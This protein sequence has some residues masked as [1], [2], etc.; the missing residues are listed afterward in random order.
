[1][2]LATKNNAIIVKDGKLAENCGCCGGWY[3]YDEKCVSCQSGAYPVAIN[4]SVEMHVNDG[5]VTFNAKLVRGPTQDQGACASYGFYVGPCAN[6]RQVGYTSLIAPTVQFTY[7]DLGQTFQA[8]F[9][10]SMGIA[11]DFGGSCFTAN[12]DGQLTPYQTRLS[13]SDLRTNCIVAPL[14]FNVASGPVVGNALM[15]TSAP[16]CYADYPGVSG[17]SISAGSD[18]VKYGGTISL[19]VLS[20]E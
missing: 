11:L 19:T 5:S 3:C 4:T 9:T 2:P 6:P 14:R 7:T 13:F 16:L 8:R 18:F 1:M 15:S 17:L 10:V 12:N 20:V